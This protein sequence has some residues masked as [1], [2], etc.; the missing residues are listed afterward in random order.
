M[1]SILASNYNSSSDSEGAEERAAVPKPDFPATEIIE[2]ISETEK[3]TKSD[4]VKEDVNMN[5][6][7]QREKVECSSQRERLLPPEPQ[8]ACDP[9]TQD[10]ISRFLSIQKERK[11]TFEEALHSKKDFANPYI[12]EKVLEYFGIDQ[13]QS[14]FPLEIF[15]PK[16][17]P[18]HEYSDQ[19][20]FRQKQ[21]RD[22]R[23]AREQ[24]EQHL[25]QTVPAP[26]SKYARTN[27][28]AGRKR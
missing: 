18:V 14:N 1:I 23:L 11:Q 26:A 3:P 9:N 4:I 25:Q 21:L 19:L 2:H 24:Q 6:Q 8:H 5:G 15:D 28:R 22:R 27:A 7:E 16:S 12:L 20:R 10:K 17:L 13:H